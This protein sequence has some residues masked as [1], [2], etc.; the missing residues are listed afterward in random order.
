MSLKGKWQLLLLPPA[1]FLFWLAFRSIPIRGIRS[2]AEGFGITS[3][4]LLVLYEIAAWMIMGERWRFFC[5]ENGADIRLGT[6]TGARLAGFSWSYITPGPHVGGEPV[7]LFYLTR[8]GIPARKTLPALVR[9]RAYEFFSGLFTASF[10]IFLP[11]GD[12]KTGWI[13]GVAAF[14]F[15][16]AALMPAMSRKVFR[17][18]AGF[19]LRFSG[20]RPEGRHRVYRFLKDLFHPGQK[21]N[22]SPGVSSLLVFSV[23]LAPLLTVGEMALFFNGSGVLLS[24]RAF[25][26]L[27]AVSRISHYAPV[28]G[29]V[30]VY[31]LGMI[32]ASG[33]LGLDPVVTAAY[34]LFTRFR[35]LVQ[36]GSGLIIFHTPTGAKIER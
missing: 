27:T 20:S 16:T 15:L 10:L 26:V 2:W 17:Y 33:W 23:L 25:L 7:Q 11:G 14:S 34:V 32:A 12:S 30:G 31:D 5:R 35:D 21:S 1:G 18:Y 22:R 36:V 9:D 13:S 24:W 4:V 29:A 28:P 8:K 3:L 6:A 19:I